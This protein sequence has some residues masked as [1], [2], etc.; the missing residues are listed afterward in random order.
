MGR[1]I[2]ARFVCLVGGWFGMVKLRYCSRARCPESVGGWWRRAANQPSLSCL[3][4][5]R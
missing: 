1:I 5:S 4:R 3:Y 2:L